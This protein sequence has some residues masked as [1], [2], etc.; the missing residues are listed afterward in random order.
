MDW[1]SRSKYREQG[2][3]K[4]WQRVIREEKE[5]AWGDKPKWWETADLDLKRAR[6]RPVTKAQATKIITEYEW[7]GTMANTRWHFGVFFGGCLGG[8]T[9][10]GS[11]DGDT[12]GRNTASMFGV[13]ADRCLIIARGACAHWTPPGAASKLISW[14]CK[15]LAR[16]SV[17]DVVMAYGDPEAGEI[18]T[19]YQACG[20][21]YVG[22]SGVQPDCAMS[23]HGRILHSRSVGDWARK[24]GLTQG[25]M[26][27]VL[28]EAGWQGK[29]L[30]PKYR[31]C[32]VIAEGAK[33]RAILHKI[34]PLIRPYPKRPLSREALANEG[35][36]REPDP[37][38][39]ILETA[40][41]E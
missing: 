20:W 19:V 30:V 39:P 17:G 13:P 38:A 21:R 5:Q 24:N 26:Q 4:A 15:L 22:T 28:A 2:T 33:R 25:E 1:A 27:K 16:D 8:V 29:E 11:N 18:G 23:P 12:G 34:A 35:R 10:V 41:S 31:Y 9:C 37:D 40:A 14:T 3:G 6:V 32:T 36:Q 7:L